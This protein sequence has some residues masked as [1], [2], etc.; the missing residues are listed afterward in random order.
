MPQRRFHHFRDIEAFPEAATC[1]ALMCVPLHEQPLLP[2]SPLA[3]ARSE[4][5]LDQA[6]SA[7]EEG[8]EAARDVDST[9][10]RGR[11]KGKVQ[12]PSLEGARRE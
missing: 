11:R 12:Q 3:R 10:S 5:A 4:P 9:A 8:G 6:S 2:P 7:G 1:V